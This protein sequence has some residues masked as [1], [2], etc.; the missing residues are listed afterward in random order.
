MRLFL[1]LVLVLSGS[2]LA[3]EKGG[4]LYIKS[5]DTKV[6]KDPKANAA[7]VLTLQPGQEVIWN[8][9]SVKDKEWHEISVDGKKGFV[10]RADL[11][12]HAPMQEIEASTGKPI[13]AQ[14]F[15]ASGYGYTVCSFGASTTA[16]SG[17]SPAEQETRAELI[18]LE[19]LNR[20]QG[21][22]AALDAKNRELHKK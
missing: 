3:V 14:A 1:L 5:K 15:A 11:T 19:E 8:G 13:N 12:P 22:L 20:E 9:A 2:A 7:T 21:T 17:G 18:Y 6:R 16:R 10:Q 4:K